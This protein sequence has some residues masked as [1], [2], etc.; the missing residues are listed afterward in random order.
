MYGSDT[1][2][3]VAQ[4]L[5][6]HGFSAWGFEER[7]WFEQLSAL[8][9]HDGFRLCHASEDN[10]F[11]WF[12]YRSRGFERDPKRGLR[13]DLI[14]ASNAAISAT[15][16]AGIDYDIRAMEKPSDHCPVWAEVNI[17]LKG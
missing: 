7:E 14:L 3:D 12:D 17:D 16:D 4:T 8:G 13:I 10:L 15:V 5:Q 9:L 2:I 1:T 6:A 11:S